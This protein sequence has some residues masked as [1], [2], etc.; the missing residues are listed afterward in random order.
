VHLPRLPGLLVGSF[1]IRS[2]SRK[3]ATVCDM[4]SLLNLDILALQETWHENTDSLALRRAVPSGY[5]VVEAAR[6]GKLN[7]KLS[8]RTSVGGGVAIIYRSQFKAKKLTT[9]PQCK[10]F[11]YVS[12]Q[13]KVANQG[14]VVVLSMYRPGSKAFTVELFRDFMREVTSLLDALATFRCPLLLLGDLNVHFERTDDVRVGEFT[15]LLTSFDMC[16]CVQQSTHKLGGLLD[17]IIT[18]Q[19]DCVTEV[20]VTEIGVSD[21]CLNTKQVLLNSQ[22]MVS[23]MLQ[24][25]HYNMDT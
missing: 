20:E 22:H 25:S 18:R 10:T 23:Y 7:V 6:T 13:L 11:E 21:H 16:Q 4:I 24:C 17:V 14:D 12:C 3:S 15:D 8:A 19:H 1:N 5:S 9:L 2:V